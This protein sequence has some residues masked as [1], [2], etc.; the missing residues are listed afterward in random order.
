MF[1]IYNYII[2]KVNIKMII[3][4]NF[5]K[6]VIA[7]RFMGLCY[8][9]S[10]STDSIPVKILNLIEFRSSVFCMTGSGSLHEQYALQTVACSVIF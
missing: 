10:L 7:T 9:I 3:F 2:Y 8:T 1:I 5:Y 4:A 6:L